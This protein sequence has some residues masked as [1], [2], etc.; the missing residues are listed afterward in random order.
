[1]TREDRG[2]SQLTVLAA[3]GLVA[4]EAGVFNMGEPP[5]GFFLLRGI[6]GEV[7]G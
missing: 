3:R 1:M 6:T 4:A 7:P 5:C 2:L